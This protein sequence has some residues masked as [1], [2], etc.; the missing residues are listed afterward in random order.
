[1]LS[2]A[3]WAIVLLSLRVALVATA[4]SLPFAVLL[5]YA[6]ARRRIPAPFAVEVLLQLPLVLPPVVTGLLLLYAIGPQSPVGRIFERVGM[7]L[8][9][10]WTGAA[11][12]AAV[13]AFPLMLQTIRAA[14]EQ[15]DPDVEHA[16][17]VSGASRWGVLRYITLPIAARGI[18][19]GVVLGFARAVGEF[20][21][22][23]M[24]A[25]NIPDSTRTLPLAI[26]T[27]FNV[28]DGGTRVF[29]LALAAM[30]LSVGSLCVHAL[31]VRRLYRVDSDGTTL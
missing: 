5:G 19:A 28:V 10:H 9:F 30:A 2:S 31:L 25:G 12:A 3:E 23:I 27:A 1:M 17:L 4:V 6:L 15:I 18:A 26:Y 24:F 11:I 7:P 22:T 21:A 13:M 14:F 20:G 29:R 8:A 16:G